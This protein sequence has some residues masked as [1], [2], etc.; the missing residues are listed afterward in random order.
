MTWMGLFVLVFPWDFLLCQ[1]VALGVAL[2]LNICRQLLRIWEGYDAYRVRAKR[3][4]D[5]TP[6]QLALEA[7]Q[8]A[9]KE[10]KKQEVQTLDDVLKETDDTIAMVSFIFKS[11][12]IF[13]WV[14]R[15][16]HCIC[17]ISFVCGLKV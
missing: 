15:T 10:Q 12:C 6:D 17:V 5:K 13:L 4:A 14:N 2:T 1:V 7:T 9:M 8:D 16:C 3:N 11:L